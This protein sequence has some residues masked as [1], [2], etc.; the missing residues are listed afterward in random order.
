M[1]ENCANNRIKLDDIIEKVASVLMYVYS[2]TI[3]AAVV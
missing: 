2:L 1:T 3:M